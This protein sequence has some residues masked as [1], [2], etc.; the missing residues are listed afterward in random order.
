MNKHWLSQHE[1][2]TYV[3]YCITRRVPMKEKR[4]FTKVSDI[5]NT[6][7]KS[8][9]SHRIIPLNGTT[10]TDC[11]AQLTIKV[12]NSHKYYNHPYEVNLIIWCQ[13]HSI[14]SSKLVKG[15]RKAFVSIC[16]RALSIFCQTAI[17][18]HEL[19]LLS[20]YS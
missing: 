10:K 7:E 14:I 5:V 1:D 19:N 9:R 4:S 3:A 17:Y 11:P 20:I 12:H 2:Q 15:Q 8:H 18:V 13:C 16:T 6:K